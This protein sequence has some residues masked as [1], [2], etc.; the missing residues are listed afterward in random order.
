MLLSL[1]LCIATQAGVANPRGDQEF[2][3]FR[4]EG[5]Q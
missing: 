5:G 2:T 3:H 1:K 4:L